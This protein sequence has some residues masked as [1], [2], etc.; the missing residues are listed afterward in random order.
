MKK[1]FLCWICYSQIDILLL[2][3]VGVDFSGW[4]LF[5]H[6][7][8]SI[9]AI[10]TKKFK[11]L[12]KKL[13]KNKHHIQSFF[14]NESLLLWILLKNMSKFLSNNSFSQNQGSKHLILLVVSLKKNL[15]NKKLFLTY[16]ES[17]II[18][19]APVRNVNH[20]INLLFF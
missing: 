20:F 9:I 1:Y 2:N 14:K 13:F 16:S 19:K 7:D 12:K 3:S 17:M 8:I 4:D 5:Q 11:S 10:V 18:S 15:F 6:H